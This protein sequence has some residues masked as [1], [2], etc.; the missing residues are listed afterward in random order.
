MTASQTR[1]SGHRT[2]GEDNLDR[3]TLTGQPG[4]DNRGRIVGT[5][6]LGQ[7]S[8]GRS[9]WTEKPHHDSKDMTARTRYP[10]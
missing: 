3:I 10:W 9:A 1:I 8:L 6:Q 4:E 2:T 7:V 5:G